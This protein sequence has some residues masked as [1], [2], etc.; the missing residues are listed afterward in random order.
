MIKKFFEGYFAFNKQQRNGLL[1]LAS[2]SFILLIVRIA[3]PYFIHPDEIE[4]KNLPLLPIEQRFSD[5][6][7]QT[8]YNQSLNTP[9]IDSHLKSLNHQ[10]F[11][12]NPNTVTFEQLLQ[13]GFK[14]KVATTFIKFRNKGFQFKRKEDLKKVYGLNETVYDSIAPYILFDNNNQHQN[15]YK[16]SSQHKNKLQIEINSAD[17]AKL[18]LVPNI[19]LSAAKRILKRRALLGGFVSAIQLNEVY[20]FEQSYCNKITPYFTFNVNLV[21]KLNLNQTTYYSLNKHPYI[22]EDLAEKIIEFRK[23][24]KINESNFYDLLK[25]RELFEKLRPY[26]SF[27]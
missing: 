7:H 18:L 9:S 4:I 2:I 16:E 21:I 27:D 11:Q 10:L 25:D 24:T 3:F 6:T 12:F 5:S 22:D 8:A 15:N 17:T 1:V 20:G 13:L 14:E 23:K 26:L 19:D